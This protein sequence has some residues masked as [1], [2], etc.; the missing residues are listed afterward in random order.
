VR[1]ALS[2]SLRIA[3]VEDE[4]AHI[5]AIRRAFAETGSDAEVLAVESLGAFR[6]L[7]ATATPDIALMNLNLPDGQALEMLSAPPEAGAFPILLMTN[8]GDQQTAV[9]AIKAGALDYLVKS[10]EVFADLPHLVSRA[11]REWSL[12]QER[13]QAIAGLRESETRFRQMAEAMGETFW[14]QDIRT[15]RILYVNPAFE[16]LWGRSRESLAGNP[17]LFMD[18]I[19]P[20]DR[21]RIEKSSEILRT[22][23][24]PFSYSEEYRIIRPDGS[25]RWVQAR[26]RPV[27]D[28]ARNPIRYAGIAEDITTRRRAQ[29]ALLESEEKYRGISRQFHELLDAIP[30][31]ITV[32]TPDLRVIWANKAAATKMGREPAAMYGLTC[33]LLRFERAEPCRDC[34]V[35]A[36]VASRSP[37]RT[38]KIDRNGRI[39]ESRAI[40]VIED[41]CAINIINVVRD[42]TD[43]TRL[44]EQLRQ[45]QKMESIGTLAGGVAHDFNNILTSVIGYGHMAMVKAGTDA[46]VRPYIQSMLEGTDRA[47]KLTDGLLTFSRKQLITKKP[48]DV[49]VLVRKAEGLIA[50]V[51]GDGVRFTVVLPEDEIPILA[52]AGRIEQ[53]LVHLATNARDAMPRGGTFTL[54]VERVHLDADRAATLAGGSAGTFAVISATDTGSGMTDAIRT[55]IYEPFYTTKDVGKGTGLGL[56][57]IHGIVEQHDGFIDLESAPGRGTTFRIFLPAIALTAAREEPQSPEPVTIVGGETILL[58]DDDTAVRLMT[59]TVLEEYGYHVVAAADGEEA[60]RLFRD[61]PGAIDLLLFDLVMPKMGG[62]DAFEKIRK[63]Q[64]QVPALFMSGYS[65][66]FVRRREVMGAEMTVLLKPVSPIDLLI[67]VR[68]ILDTV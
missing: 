6:D 68:S 7:I 28:D 14:L 12:L 16:T 48:L 25:V 32:Q 41:G 36:C 13:A 20:E 49:V 17:D 29:T 4:G 38:I 15:R 26:I 56:S 60:V 5:A 19:H 40:P 44:E 37:A 53:V 11:L 31:D 59:R 18:C 62:K 55:R 54:A 47:A 57:I 34:P 52:D 43:Q 35:Q 1:E 10:A 8:H 50:R 64:P 58:A 33:H 22:S 45:A 3:L 27:F 9:D 21:H 63:I 24:M 67:K 30:E 23:E 66:D 2:R 39:F 61:Y 65:D 46:D 42:I 51:V